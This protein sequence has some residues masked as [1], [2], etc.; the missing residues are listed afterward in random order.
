LLKLEELRIYKLTLVI[1]RFNTNLARNMPSRF[2]LLSTLEKQFRVL[3]AVN[4]K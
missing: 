3:S 4:S 2:L 1:P